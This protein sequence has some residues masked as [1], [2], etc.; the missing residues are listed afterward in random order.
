M[1]EIL[2]TEV[3]APVRTRSLR[4]EPGPPRQLLLGD[5][6]LATEDLV[7]W[8][9]M[10]QQV[11]RMPPGCTVAWIGSGFCL[12]PRIARGRVGRQTVYEKRP[13]VARFIPSFCTT[14]VGDYRS[15][16]TGT[17]DV[18]VYDV[19]D[20]PDRELLNAHLAPGGLLLGVD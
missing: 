3:D 10:A 15:A 7:E 5:E 2:A 16:L 20:E 13:A 11:V 18:I 17:F 14:V 6:V 1:S 9:R 12:G 19:G 8:G 4:V